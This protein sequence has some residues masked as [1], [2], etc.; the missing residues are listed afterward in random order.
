MT[1]RVSVLIPSRNEGILVRRTV[2]NVLRTGGPLLK[3]IVV[4]DD[5]STDMS[6]NNLTGTESVPVKVVRAPGGHLSRAKNLGLEHVTGDVVMSLDAHSWPQDG[7]LEP[8]CEVIDM[9]NASAS[10]SIKFCDRKGN[11]TPGEPSVARWYARA[12]LPFGMGEWPTTHGS[13]VPL[14]YGGCQ[15]F[16]RELFDAVGG[17]CE[18]MEFGGEDLEMCLRIWRQGY[19]IGAAPEALIYTLEKEWN[20][21]PDADE[22]L[23]ATHTNMVKVQALHWNTPR[24]IE[25][26]AE[27]AARWKGHPDL[28]EA[29]WQGCATSEVTELRQQYEAKSVLTD[30]EVFERFPLM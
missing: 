25:M 10:P 30:N 3:E 7:W 21:R 11:P 4:V 17:F 16:S 28:L 29:V 18:L 8:L 24:L 5:G 27:L 9:G 20:E 1:G 19:T 2:D 12:D 26:W 23:V 22:I 14:A 15:A 13:P 6:C